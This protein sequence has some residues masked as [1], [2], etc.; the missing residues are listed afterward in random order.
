VRVAADYKLSLRG[1]DKGSEAYVEALEDCHARSADKVLQ[2]CRAQAGVYIKAGQLL[3]SLRPVVPRQFTDALA[4]LCDDA[5]QSPLH[6]VRRVFREE[7]GADMEQIFHH[8][9]PKPIGCASLAQVH[10]AWLR[11]QDGSEGKMVAVKVQHAWMSKHTQ[12]DTLVM[13][14]AAQILELLF[15]DVEIKWLIPV[16]R[17]N[18]SSEL[19]FMCEA[20]NMQRCARNFDGDPGVRVPELLKNFTSKRVLTMEYINGVKVNDV[21]GLRAHGFDPARVGREV[22][23]IFGE[24]VFCHGF[25]H[26]D[27]H[28]GNMLVTKP[29]HA[30]GG[31]GAGRAGRDD[32]D[33]VVLDHGLYREIPNQMRLG[34]CEMWEAMILQ[35][36]AALQKV[37][38]A[39]GVG[40]YARLFPLIFT[41]RAID[42]KVKLG[43]R[44]SKEE[45]VRVRDTLG[46]TGF[47]KDNFKIAEVL[48]FT[49]RIP[50]DLL[51]IIRTQNLVRSLCADL[52]YHP[53]QR[54]RLYASLAARG[55][56][57]HNPLVGTHAE[58][59]WRQECDPSTDEK[60][61]M[62]PD[63]GARADEWQ[64][65]GVHRPSSALR[66]W[67]LLRSL[68]L[69]I[70]MFFIE[71][72]LLLLFPSSCLSSH[73]L[74]AP[75]V[76]FSRSTRGTLAGVFVALVR[77]FKSGT[78][79]RS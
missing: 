73:A 3:A 16:F 48:H 79:C 74:C 65:A 49:E 75:P 18:L 58:D 5:P 40:E 14:T 43:D 78:L 53:R 33:V 7:L 63:S 37:A 36:A 13:E 31:G 54:F 56:A 51:F 41:M 4:Q 27:P 67:Q 11:E 34:Y 28:P 6:D 50:R 44:M 55:K 45:R 57:L 42:S 8:V 47:S 46:V 35:D 38:D 17:R 21:D 29:Q 2:L 64:V 20:S 52:G 25:V 19:N 60:P 76:G 24:M 68:N 26:C 1:V 22:T 59:M 70:R 10:R 9:D 66:V 23:R 39:M 62:A 32:F 61:L 15:P 72:L 12:S 71:V 77:L 30:A 69:E